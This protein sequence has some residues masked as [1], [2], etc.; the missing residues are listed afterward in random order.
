MATSSKNTKKSAC[1]EKVKKSFQVGM[2]IGRNMKKSN[3]KK[4]K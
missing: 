2:N 3:S 1:G 4:K